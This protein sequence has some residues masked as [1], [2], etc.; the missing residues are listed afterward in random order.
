MNPNNPNGGV[1]TEDQMNAGDRFTS[2]VNNGQSPSQASSTVSATTPYF[3]SPAIP[4]TTNTT[5]TSI[6]P[7]PNTTSNTPNQAPTSNI[8]AT[9]L[10]QTPT[11]FQVAP[12]S[13][14]QNQITD[15]NAFISS[16]NAYIGNTAGQ[17]TG[18]ENKQSD[19]INRLA[20]A[21]T[22]E[23]QK[24]GAQLGLEQNMGVPQYMKQIQDLNTS[25]AQMSGQYLQAEQNALQSGEGSSFGQ[26]AYGM[27]QRSAAISLGTQAALLQAYQGNLTT[28]QN[29]ASHVVNLQFQ[30]I[31]NQIQSLKDQIAANGDVMTAQQADRAESL[32]AALDIQQE[33]VG[34]AKTDKQNQFTL[35]QDYIQQTGD[36]QGGMKIA[37][38]SSLSDALSI[39]ST[40]YGGTAPISQ[41]TIDKANGV[42]TGQDGKKYDLTSYA[43]D[44]Q[45]LKNITATTSVIQNK[46]GTITDANTAQE[47]IDAVNPKSSITGAQVMA[48]AQQY[49]VDP[50]MIIGVMNAETQ[51]GTDKSK[52]SQMNNFGNVGNTDSAMANG[53]PTKYKTSQEGIDALAENLAGRTTT[54]NQQTPSGLAD[55]NNLVASAPANIRSLIHHEDATGVSYMDYSDTTQA[56]NW[57]KNHGIEMLPKGVSAID[58]ANITNA[59]QAVNDAQEKFIATNPPEGAT[60]KFFS[61]V[62][63]KAGSVFG[64]TAGNAIKD[65]TSDSFVTSFLKAINPIIGDA[66]LTKN[67]STIGS[68]DLPFVPSTLLG[69]FAGNADSKE[70]GITQFNSLR[71]KLNTVLHNILPNAPTIP[72][73]S[74]DG[75]TGFSVTD[76]NGA[77]HTFKDQASLDAFKKAAKL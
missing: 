22:T 29:Y 53:T 28:A 76:P 51:M 57:A 5:G 66:R 59:I 56:A 52:G 50:T 19:L 62:A 18:S 20:S 77:V 4:T 58:V 68:S 30:P 43:T 8:S 60:E 26:G 16:L 6:P 63:N 17:P 48:A 1:L 64:T 46:V 37:N 49:G 44:P 39:Y 34:Q 69:G 14:S 65:Y 61:G 47:A 24:G 42:L 70:Q 55:Y 13:Q 45:Q 36:T 54:T 7:L 40:A 67:T 41:D 31:E 25:I 9:D 11:N 2:A 72:Q 74:S 27:A 23:G 75:T 3:S 71:T 10:R 15:P 38:S 33:S 35:A 32:T 21:N 12:S 73:T